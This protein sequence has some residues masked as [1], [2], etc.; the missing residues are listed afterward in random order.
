MGAYTNAT[1]KSPVWPE[2]ATG[3]WQSKNRYRNQSEIMAV[4]RR[5]KS[6]GLPLTVIAIDYYS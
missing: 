2:W 6:L 5:Y 4:A 1:G 3:F